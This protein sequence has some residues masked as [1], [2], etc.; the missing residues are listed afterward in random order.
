MSGTGERWEGGPDW[1]DWG[2]ERILLS[3]ESI[4]DR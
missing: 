4:N 1:G 3:D 2:L